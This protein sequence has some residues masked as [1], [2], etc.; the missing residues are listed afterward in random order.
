[1]NKILLAGILVLLLF[2]GTAAAVSVN[3]A[4]TQSI[5]LNTARDNANSALLSYVAQ[6]KLGSSTALW[7]GASLSPVP[8]II[9]DQS[10]VVYSYLFDVVN[11]N[12]IIVGQVNA[13]GNKIIGV[14]VISIEKT[15]RSF[16]PAIVIPKIRETAQEAYAGSTIDYVVFV[17]TQDKKIAAM[18]ILTE[19]NGLSHRLIYD[20]RT[21]RLLS[22][23]ITYPGLI[24]AST[25]SSVFVSMS[26]SS[27]SR[28]IQ[29]YETR[30]KSVARVV[31]VMRR[32]VPA[33]YLKPTSTVVPGASVVKSA[34]KGNSLSY[35]VTEPLVTT[36]LRP[37]TTAI[38]VNIPKEMT[39]VST[40]NLRQ[41]LSVH[42]FLLV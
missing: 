23:R 2:V 1:M 7:K 16:D 37:Y 41:P 5:P 8:I 15:P 20:I 42:R 17:M 29:N 12:G 11:K 24:D 10:G 13:A 31:P 21:S 28:A 35:Y 40:S 26:S 30:T 19:Q 4:Q 34:E 36:Q 6:G 39:P 38:S 22:E 33:N 27:A 18:V 9:Y 25:P 3:Y 14:P 32:V